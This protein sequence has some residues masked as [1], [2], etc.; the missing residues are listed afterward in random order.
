MSLQEKFEELSV[1]TL[2]LGD[3]EFIHQH[4]VDAFA[5]Q[6]AD[7]TT[8]TIKIFFA[9]AGLY[10]SVE[11]NYTG[12]EV[13]N[14][15]VQMSRNKEAFSHFNVVLPEFRGEITVADVLHLPPGAARNDMICRW[16]DAVWA[17]FGKQRSEIIALTESLL[18][19]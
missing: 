6:T 11:K 1:Y 17:A 5:V 14:A 19:R 12:K 2:S 15:H 7:E 9:L 18:N 16:R 3:Q 10:L 13:Q 8:K 4:A